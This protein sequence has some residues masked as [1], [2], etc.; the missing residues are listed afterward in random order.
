VLFLKNANM[1]ELSHIGS[2]I[3]LV[4]PWAAGFSLTF[5]LPARAKVVALDWQI[6]FFS[7]EAFWE[8]MF[9]GLYPYLDVCGEKVS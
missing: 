9:L 5:F 8:C 7:G 1:A 4:S 2:A 3:A 6:M